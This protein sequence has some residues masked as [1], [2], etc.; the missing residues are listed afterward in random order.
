[1]CVNM[2]KEYIENLVD[3]I[4]AEAKTGKV[5]V[6]DNTGESFCYYVRFYEKQ[7]NVKKTYPCFDI[8][9]VELFDKK[10]AE[11]LLEAR[12]FYAKSPETNIF[13]GR[14]LDKRFVLNMLLNANYA[15][16]TNPIEYVIERTQMLKNQ[17]Q[18]FEHEFEYNGIKATCKVEKLPSN[19]EG[20]Y[21][22]E[23][24]FEKNGEEYTLPAIVFGLDGSHAKVFACQNF[25]AKT[26]KETLVKKK[27]G[28][29]LYKLN[30]GVPENDIAGDVSVSS[31]AAATIFMQYL[32]AQNIT[33]IEAPVF[34]P[35]RSHTNKISKY[36]RAKRTG[37]S[38][39][40]VAEKNNLDQFNM[41]NKFAYLFE[42]LAYHFDNFET[43]YDDNTMTTY[44][45]ILPNKATTNENIIF[46]I[47]KSFDFEN[48]QIERE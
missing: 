26:N 5:T 14:G 38:V 34:L 45:H 6:P 19:L 22:F 39:R 24:T 31:V 10:N 1:M 17:P 8:N 36:N 11:Y 37:E 33:K 43:F 27:L 3:E 15:D 13:E 23:T 46:D 29:H 28:R 2:D 42:R 12:K 35:L 18:I 48:N 32:K 41:T 7:D 25:A 47:A 9:N 30:S 40:A 44:A 21:K 16:M 4:F 20:P